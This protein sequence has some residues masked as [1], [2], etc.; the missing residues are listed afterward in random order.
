MKFVIWF[1]VRYVKISRKKLFLLMIPL[2]EVKQSLSGRVLE[3]RRKK[4][5]CQ[6][7]V[8]EHSFLID[9]DCF[10]GTNAQR[11]K[12][13]FAPALHSAYTALGKHLVSPGS[14]R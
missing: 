10:L 11:S 3:G 7:E 4:A 9:L 8:F 2:S 5:V 14:C 12:P 6:S 1:R 13:E